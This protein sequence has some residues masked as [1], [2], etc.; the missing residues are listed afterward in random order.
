MSP[1]APSGPAVL[2]SCLGHGPP[3]HGWPAARSLH[4]T[5]G[6]PKS[7]WWYMFHASTAPDGVRCRIGL[8]PSPPVCRGLAWTG[9]S[10]SLARLVP[11]PRAVGSLARTATVDV[12]GS[13]LW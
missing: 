4:T 5:F 9:A 2:L 8:N 11:V 1:V 6:A 13:V 12:P 7:A 10:R 3:G